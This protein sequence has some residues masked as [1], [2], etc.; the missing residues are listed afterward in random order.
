MRLLTL[1]V[2]AGALVATA[3]SAQAESVDEAP[4]AEMVSL[5]SAVDGPFTATGRSVCSSG[6]VAT[7]FNFFLGSTP[8]GFKLV[9]G[10]K[11][12]CDDGSGTFDLA[13][14]VQVRPGAP[15]NSFRWMVTEGTGE[16]DG[17]LGAGTGYGDSTD[18][19]DHY[20]GRVRSNH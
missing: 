3:A 17:L 19:L 16:F 15:R 2:L 11:F 9:V 6:E 13:L 1:L 4:Y 20:S 8:D 5:V 10:K 12:S 7:T 18:S 14:H